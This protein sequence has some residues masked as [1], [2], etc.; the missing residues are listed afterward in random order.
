MKTK[1]HPPFHETIA[2]LRNK[3]DLKWLRVKMSYHKF[4]NLG[5]TFQSDLTSKLTRDVKS[6]DLMNLPCNC[7]AKTKV[8]GKCMFKGDCQKSILVYT[9]KCKLYDMSYFGNTQQKLKLRIN[10]HPAGVCALVDKGKILAH[11]QTI[12][13]HIIKTEKRN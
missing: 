3:Y 5:S 6:M 12:L 7:N 10:Q 9:A 2:K 8:D 11:L 13:C 1:K 4:P